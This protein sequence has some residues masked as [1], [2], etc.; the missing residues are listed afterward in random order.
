MQFDKLTFS[1]G[2][3]R[4]NKCALWH[5]VKTLRYYLSLIT[6][7]YQALK[8][9]DFSINKVPATNLKL[10]SA[11]MGPIQQK[12]DEM[13]L[14]DQVALLFRREQWSSDTF[15]VWEHQRVPTDFSAT[16]V[17]SQKFKRRANFLY[18]HR[19][20]VGPG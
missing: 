12:L 19:V 6:Y 15:R 7:L 14:E 13:I 8:E 9:F 2:F 10:L 16:N 3:K 5:K 11:T 20:V 1:L 4:P 18:C 17:K